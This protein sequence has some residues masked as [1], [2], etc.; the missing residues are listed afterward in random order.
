[1]IGL[2]P[3]VAFF[4]AWYA[5]SA[6]LIGH[7]LLAL[8]ADYSS[9]LPPTTHHPALVSAAS[10]SSCDADQPDGPIMKMGKHAQIAQTRV[11]GTRRAA[12]AGAGSGRTSSP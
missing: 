10:G 6:Y 8:L 3:R 9:E 4:M 5:A 1:V 11:M 12:V 2:W 7:H